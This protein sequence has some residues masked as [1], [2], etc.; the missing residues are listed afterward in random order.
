MTTV[1][2]DT[3]TRSTQ[4]LDRWDIGLV[5][6]EPNIVQSAIARNVFFT[7]ASLKRYF[8]HLRS[9]HEFRTSENYLGGLEITFKGDMSQL[10][11]N[12]REKLTAC[13]DLLHK[14]ESELRAQITD[15]KGTIDFHPRQIQAIFTDKTLNFA[16][17]RAQINR[18]SE[19]F[20]Q[21]FLPGKEWFAYDT[22]YGTSEEQ[23]LVKFLTRWLRKWESTYDVRYLLRN[24]RQFAIY[25]FSD[26][27][28]FEPDFVLFLGK[29]NGE[30]AIYQLFIEPKGNQ[31]RL[32]DRWKEDFLKEIDAK[33]HRSTLTEN[34]EYRVIG[35]PFYTQ[36]YE[37]DFGSALNE[38]LEHTPQPDNQA[39]S[40]TE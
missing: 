37:N 25:N 11:D 18:V 7:F 38:A 6:I 5:D 39:E 40:A 8:P 28:A 3:E 27:R 16:A 24:E 10:E 15:Y 12:P 26:G 34:S 17:S 19:D 33:Y 20:N 21:Y 30:S 32:P 29:T 2:D 14:V 13:C 9:M 36:I 23:G 4:V 35:I 22:L 31:L 1:M